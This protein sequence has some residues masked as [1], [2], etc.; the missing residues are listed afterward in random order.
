MVKC[1]LLPNQPEVKMPDNTRKET[2]IIRWAHLDTNLLVT[3]YIFLLFQQS[4]QDTINV[5][6]KTNSIQWL[7]IQCCLPKSKHASVKQWCELSDKRMSLFS[8]T[9]FKNRDCHKIIWLLMANTDLEDK[10]CCREH[11]GFT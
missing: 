3:V 4:M 2:A 9:T 10:S 5:L 7:F 8:G 11:N 6:I 1:C